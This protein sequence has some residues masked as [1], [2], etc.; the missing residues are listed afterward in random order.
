MSSWHHPACWLATS[1][2]GH[3]Y[4][5]QVGTDAVTSQAHCVVLST[6]TSYAH[7]ICPCSTL[8]HSYVQ[9]V[10]PVTAEEVLKLYR[11]RQMKVRVVWV[12]E[13]RKQV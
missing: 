2:W 4:K 3:M 10:G 6:M 1:M 5:L 7:V 8:E 9:F 13:F 12:P 11:E